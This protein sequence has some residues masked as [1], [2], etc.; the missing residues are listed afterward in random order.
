MISKITAAKWTHF[1]TQYV[2]DILKDCDVTFVL[3][4]SDYSKIIPVHFYYLYYWN[5][6]TQAPVGVPV[7][8]EVPILQLGWLNNGIEFVDFMIIDNKYEIVN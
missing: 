1:E 8:V 7:P 4:C 3:K 5:M 6:D 2:K